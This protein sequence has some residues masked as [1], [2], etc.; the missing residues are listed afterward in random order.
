MSA[1]KRRRIDNDAAMNECFGEIISELDLEIALR[2]RVAETIESRITW[3][4]ILQESLKKGSSGSTA[5]FKDAALEAVSAIEAPLDDIFNREKAPIVPPLYV[6]PP[7]PP[8]PPHKQQAVRNPNAKF[9][10][11]RSSD[12]EPPY[13]ENHVQTYLLRCPTCLRQKFTS[14][15]GLLNHARITHRMEWGSH[16]ECVRACAVVDPELDVEFG[17]EVG[18]GPNGILPGIRSLFHMAVGSHRPLEFQAQGEGEAAVTGG[19]VETPP[20]VA[21]VTKTLGLHEDTPALATFLGKEAT[22]RCIKLWGNA[23]DFVDIEGFDHNGSKV[24]TG[25]QMPND[26]N[27][28]GELHRPWRMHF[29]HRNDFEPETERKM[30]EIT[31]SNT[32]EKSLIAGKIDPEGSEEDRTA[33][34]VP[35]KSGL[36]RSRFHFAARV[37]VSHHIT[38]I[39]KCLTISSLSNSG[40]APLTTSKPPFVIVGNA[41]KPFLA[42][43]ELQFSGP[44][45]PDGEA[46]EQTVILEH[47]VK[48]DLSNSPT[49]V[50]GEEQMVDI[51]LDRGTILLPVQNGYAA[52]SSKAHWSKTSESL[53][54]LSEVMSQLGKNYSDILKS[55]V[56]KFPMTFT[57]EMKASRQA[58]PQVPYK[59]FPT[60]QFETLIPGRRKMIEWSRARALQD[61]YTWEIREG[62]LRSQ[63]LIPLTTADVY[64]WLLEEGHFIRPP[65]VVGIK[66]ENLDTPRE[67]G[68]IG[69]GTHPVSPA[70]KTEVVRLLE[71]VKL[72]PEDNTG[73]AGPQPGTPSPCN[74]PTGP[75]RMPMIDVFSRLPSG[76]GSGT[77]VHSADA[78]IKDIRDADLV[79]AANPKLTLAVHEIVSTL[80]L[81]TFPSPSSDVETVYPLDKLGTNQA[82]AESR[83]A[84]HATL[85]MVARRFI[86]VLVEGGL[87][88]IKREQEA[89]SGG[90]SAEKGTAE[91]TSSSG[92]LAPSHIIS[93]VVTRRDASSSQ[94][95]SLDIAMFECLS[96]LGV[97]ATLPDPSSSLSDQGDRVR[98]LEPVV[99]VKLED[100]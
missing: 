53:Q 16:D 18:L 56:A 32:I 97:P 6:Q 93:S 22:R 94:S 11:I 100:S 61:A 5:S 59:L 7:R 49:P 65:T 72:E 85:A 46:T 3:A 45:G 50:E 10:F 76:V 36:K 57:K 13:D 60:A 21:N 29:T 67:G 25:G 38:T 43:I 80:K 40:G 48:L 54:D 37:S 79:A 55:L 28:F 83:L 44:S 71:T 88:A 20:Q 51:E 47:W 92:V 35:Q 15:Q 9:L 34:P 87:D 77:P 89:S 14:L 30:Q 95:H 26:G 8:R 62:Q 82:Q 41:N 24:S 23:D 52:I 91:E 69:V 90:E 75:I 2:R 74:A 39:L 19:R 33:T 64:Y 98:G 81:P 63:S 73:C 58:C 68:H 70:V 99:M 4:L 12:L 84:P 66:I 78:Q 31:T 17:I 42:R 96:R 1:R 86:K 27:Y